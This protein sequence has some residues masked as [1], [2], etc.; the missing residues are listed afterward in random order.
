MAHDGLIQDLEGGRTTG[1]DGDGFAE[2]C[3]AAAAATRANGATTEE[4]SGTSGAAAFGR[5]RLSRDRV[6]SVDTA[7][8]VL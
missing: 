3:V 6:V 4:G 8:E 7:A 5:A 2:R 1:M